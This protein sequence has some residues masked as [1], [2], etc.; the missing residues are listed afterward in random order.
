MSQQGPSYQRTT[1]MPNFKKGDK[2]PTNARRKRGTVADRHTLT[3]QA[4]SNATVLTVESS[5]LP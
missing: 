4:R 2:R 5:T 1:R 3:R